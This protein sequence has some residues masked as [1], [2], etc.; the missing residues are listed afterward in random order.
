M[1][2][3]VSIDFIIFFFYMTLNRS[4]LYFSL[5]VVPKDDLSKILPYGIILSERKEIIT[6]AFGLFSRGGNFADTIFT[7]GFIYTMDEDQPRAEAVAVKDGTIIRVGTDE[8][9]QELVGDDTEVFD[10]EGMY[11]LPGFIEANDSP[12]LDMI[13]EDVCLVL[14]DFSSR[15]EVLKDL[16]DYIYTHPENEVY[17]GYGFAPD[18]LQDLAPEDIPVAVDE[19]C[20]DKPVLLLSKDGLS[21]WFN[22]CAAEAVLEVTDEDEAPFITLPYMLRTLAPIEPDRLELSAMDVLHGYCSEGFTTI[23]EGSASPFLCHAAE[24]LMLEM[25]SQDMAKLRYVNGIYICH[26]TDTSYVDSMIQNKATKFSELGGLMMGGIVA[27][28]II[29]GNL[30]E[31]YLVELMKTAQVRSSDIHIEAHDSDDLDLARSAIKKFRESAGHKNQISLAHNGELLE[32][33]TH[34][35]FPLVPESASPEE[36]IK[37]R[38]VRAAEKL[39]LSELIGKIAEGMF[40]DFACFEEN[41]FAGRGARIPNAAMTVLG[42]EIVYDAED[43]DEENWRLATFEQIL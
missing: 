25:V 38:T 39:G 11:M 4:I 13:D 28:S 32:T 30:S 40:A 18:L 42:G 37:V 41:P 7:G 20:D 26:E 14:D 35:E 15:E 27:P 29:G 19:V 31:D 23:F 17:F 43:E 5:F 16:K 36:E 21:G 22:T 10:L 12:V 2:S 34:F 6:M 33:D 8:D 3:F 1:F 9:M 24:D